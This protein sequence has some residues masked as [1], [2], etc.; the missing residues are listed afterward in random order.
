MRRAVE[1]SPVLEEG[2]VARPFVWLGDGEQGERVVG[3]A[4]FVTT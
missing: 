3:E 4:G 2:V 1:M